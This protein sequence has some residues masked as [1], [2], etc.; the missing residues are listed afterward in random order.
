M[1]LV[2]VVVH[3]DG[4]VSGGSTT[5]DGWDRSDSVDPQ[6][7]AEEGDGLGVMPHQTAQLPPLPRLHLALGQS[8]L[9]IPDAGGHLGSVDPASAAGTNSHLQQTITQGWG[10][11]KIIKVQGAVKALPG[12][13]EVEHHLL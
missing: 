1:T 5:V 2:E 9:D 6:V 13:D 10:S 8:A 4:R 3:C 7:G 11:V 12:L